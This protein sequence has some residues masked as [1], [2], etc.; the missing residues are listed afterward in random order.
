M[1]LFWNPIFT[2]ISNIYIYIYIYTPSQWRR[3]FLHFM[4]HPRQLQE[5]QKKN[6]I[7]PV[8]VVLIFFPYFLQIPT[9]QTDC[10]IL[11]QIYN[12]QFQ[13]KPINPNRLLGFFWV[14][15][16]HVGGWRK[17]KRYLMEIG[18]KQVDEKKSE[19]NK[20]L[21]WV[22]YICHHIRKFTK[23]KITIA[24]RHNKLSQY[25]HNNWGVKYFIYQNKIK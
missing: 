15:K 23:I 16:R 8:V 20:K 11:N 9:N 17:R 3:I 14:K 1:F 4:L 10:K 22:G 13:C 18:K 7:V 2:Q 6:P 21:V 25:F 5:G 24:L 19:E 12:F